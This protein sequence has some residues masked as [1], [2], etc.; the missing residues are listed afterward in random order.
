MMR[1][2]WRPVRAGGVLKAFGETAI[3]FPIKVSG[4]FFG[5]DAASDLVATGLDP[6]L[7]AAELKDPAQF[8]YR[9][10]GA[11]PVL[12]SRAMLDAYNTA[13]A[14]MNGFPQPQARVHPGLPFRPHP[15]PKLPGRQ[16]LPGAG[17]ARTMRIG[18]L[19]N[20]GRAARHH[21]PRRIRTPFQPGIHRPRRPLCRRLHRRQKPRGASP[22]SKPGPR[23][24]ASAFKPRRKGPR[25][26]SDA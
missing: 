5:H 25:T 9:E 18:G 17:A 3:A 12:V 8:A 10:K 13:F 20:H 22:A 7:V 14:P 4:S 23:T 16:Q 21:P 15:G 19:L 24:K 26:K 2:C 11:I 6:E 1:F